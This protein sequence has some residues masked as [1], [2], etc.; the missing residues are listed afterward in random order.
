MYTILIKIPFL[1]RLAAKAQ[2]AL[3]VLIPE[4]YADGLEYLPLRLLS[5][6]I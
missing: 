4:F 5:P 1:R 6:D 2:E 3:P